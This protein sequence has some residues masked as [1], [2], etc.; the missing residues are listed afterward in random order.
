MSDYFKEFLA[1][2]RSLLTDT[3]TPRKMAAKS[4]PIKKEHMGLTETDP[5]KAF[6]KKV[7]D[8]KPPKKELVKEF[9]RFCDA[10]EEAL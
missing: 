8:E 6:I 1:S 2:G 3:K 10:A 9:K 4:R 5:Y 7:I